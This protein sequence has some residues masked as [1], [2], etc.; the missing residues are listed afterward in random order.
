M[1]E[2]LLYILLALLLLLYL[3]AIFASQILERLHVAHLLVLHH[4]AHCTA[5]LAAAEAFVDALARRHRETRCLL[6]MERT[7]RN[8][9]CPPSLEGDKI[10]HHLLNAGG[11]KYAFYCCVVNHSFLFISGTFW[12]SFVPGYSCQGTFRGCF[13]PDGSPAAAASLGNRKICREDYFAL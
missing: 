7:A 12:C 8:V 9:V 2:P 11:V 10:A 4:K 1:V 6:M 5:G 13:V 3:N